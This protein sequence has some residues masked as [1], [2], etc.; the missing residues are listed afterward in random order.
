M[1]DVKFSL[2]FLGAA[3]TVTGSSYLLK[4]IEGEQ[5]ACTIMV[6]H[7]MFQG[8]DVEERNHFQYDFDPSEIDYLFLTHAHVDHCGLIPKLVKYGFR[9]QI[10]TTRVTAEILQLILLDS[11]KIQLRNSQEDSS[12]I[13]YSEEDVWQ[14]MDQVSDI[15]FGEQYEIELSEGRSVKFQ[16]YRAGHVIGAASFYFE[17]NGK[18]IVFSGD[19]GRHTQELIYNFD[20]IVRPAD[21]VVMESLYGGKY[22]DDKTALLSKF[23]AEIRKAISRDGNVIIPAFAM[24]RTQEMLFTLSYLIKTGQLPKN[25]QIFLDS[26]LAQRM[27]NIYTD[28]TTEISKQKLKPFTDIKSAMYPRNLAIIKKGN[29]I[30]KISKKKG[31][32]ILTGGGMINGGKVLGYMKV[33]SANPRNMLAIVGFQAEGTLGRE[34]IEGADTILIDDVKCRI[35]LEV[36]QFNGF[37]AHG[38]HDDLLNWLNAIERKQGFKVF[39]VHAE[40]EQSSAFKSSLDQLGFN[41]EIAK[42]KQTIIL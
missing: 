23:A 6:D 33:M 14:T 12:Q 25:T 10:I 13:I 15:V 30:N 19:I 41:S 7:G 16:A 11:A 40:V 37:S 26:P 18:S 24:Q 3:E 22:H 21:Y 35:A 27:N 38:D 36:K 42:N 31:V 34:I 1:A 28:N 8:P 17:Y 32:I 29:M 20:P 4:I 9:G 39:L 5:V 2:T